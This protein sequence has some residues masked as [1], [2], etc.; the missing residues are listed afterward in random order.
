MK[1]ISM[2]SRSYHQ[3]GF[4]AISGFAGGVQV[5]LRS[6]PKFFDPLKVPVED[7]AMGVLIENQMSTYSAYHH[8]GDFQK[9]AFEAAQAAL[10]AGIDENAIFVEGVAVGDASIIKASGFNATEVGNTPTPGPEGKPIVTAKRGEYS[11]DI[12]S[13][14]SMYPDS[15]QYGCIVSV[16]KPLDVGVIITN[17]GNL[18]IP[19]SQT[20]IIMINLTSQRRKSFTGLTPKVDYWFY[21]FVVNTNGVSALSDGVMVGCA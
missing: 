19:A 17:D 18:I 9:P 11:G 4:T 3:L 16:G 5:G 7:A 14:C 15:P 1:K 13:E 2:V 20:N 6:S 12:N 8:G 21:Y 10:I